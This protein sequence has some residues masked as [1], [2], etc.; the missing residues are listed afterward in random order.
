MKTEHH[1]HH[2]TDVKPVS[3]KHSCE[4]LPC[5][6]PTL[7]R[8]NYFTG[9]LL[10]ERDFTAEQHYFM[11]KLRLHYVALHGWGVVCGLK[12]KPHLY[13]P[14]RRIVVEAGL[15]IDGCGREIRV[16]KEIDDVLLDM[17]FEKPSEQSEEPCPPEPKVDQEREPK[18]KVEG[19]HESAQVAPPQRQYVIDEPSEPPGQPSEPCL[20]APSR[21]TLYICLR[22]AECQTEFMPAPFDECACDNAGQRPNRICQSYEIKILTEEPAGIKDIKARRDKCKI[23]DCESLYHQLLDDCPKPSDFDCIPLAVINDY[24]PGQKITEAMIDN[25]T[26]RVVLPSVSV[27]DQLIRCILEKLP[28][29]KLTRIEDYNWDHEAS[30]TCHEFMDEFI[31]DDK[32]PRNFWIQFENRL[33]EAGLTRRTFQAT[34]VRF[35]DEAGPG[36]PEIAPVR[37]WWSNDNH[38]INLEIDRRYAQTLHNL[39]FDLYIRLR[40]NLLVDERGYP[41]DGE[42]H[43]VLDE[44]NYDLAPYTGDGIPGGLFESWIRVR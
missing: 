14:D 27:L 7:C 26:Y 44:N 19:S 4:C 34:I 13:C 37:V 23:G 5:D 16:L 11:D 36:R 32:G 25:Q 9:K 6:I 42:L 39:R 8:N 30:Y 29:K 35:P 1:D 33:F 3:P 2:T 22:Y 31:G 43:A 20:P 38:R 10:T 40:C 28:T 17:E 18:P 15:A 12:V 41:V 24:T 21:Y